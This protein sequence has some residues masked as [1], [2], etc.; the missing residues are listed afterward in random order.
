[1]SLNKIK[2]TVS[3]IDGT[4][5]K[6]IESGI[7]EPRM[8][9]LKQLLEFNKFEV[10]V[11]KDKDSEHNFTIGVTDILFNPVFAVYD[12]IFNT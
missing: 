1:M 11:N 10:K 3:E 5:C 6:I 9:F 2:Y 7:S 4:R 12:R 8:N